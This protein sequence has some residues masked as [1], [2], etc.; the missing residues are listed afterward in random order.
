VQRDYYVV[1]MSNGPD[2]WVFR[3]LRNSQWYLHG[4]WS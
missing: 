4:L 1:R 3:D 2:L